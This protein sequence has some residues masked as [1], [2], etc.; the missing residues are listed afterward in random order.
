M[1]VLPEADAKAK[2]DVADASVDTVLFRIVPL[3]AHCAVGRI[4]RL[5]ILQLAVLFVNL[6]SIILSTEEQKTASPPEKLPFCHIKS[7]PF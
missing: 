4:A 1:G 3:A 7:S 5:T 6:A 2:E